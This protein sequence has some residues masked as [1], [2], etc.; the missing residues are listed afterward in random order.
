MSKIPPS[1]S[2]VVTTI[3]LPKTII[4]DIDALIASEK[5]EYTD[6]ADLIK[7]AVRKEVSWQQKK[8]TGHAIEIS[9]EV[10]PPAR[11]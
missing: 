10:E 3:R 7:C 5:T 9:A 6:R 1:K 11:R 4:E 2:S 8:I